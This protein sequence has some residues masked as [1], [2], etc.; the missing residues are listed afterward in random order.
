MN[1]STKMFPPPDVPFSLIWSQVDILS[2]K[3]NTHHYMPVEHRTDN[4]L[5]PV[6]CTDAC[7]VDEPLIIH[8]NPPC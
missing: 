3:P 1:N 4:E 5:V 8:I 7:G 6:G 2:M